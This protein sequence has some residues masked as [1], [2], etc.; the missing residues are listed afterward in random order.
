[1]MLKP[2]SEG[3]GSSRGEAMAEYVVDL[4][5]IVGREGLIAVTLR[6]CAWYQAN[7]L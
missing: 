4:T 3:C 6:D 2:V 7:I 5:V 1:M